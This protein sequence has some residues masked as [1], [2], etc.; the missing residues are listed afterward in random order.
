MNENNCRLFSKE[1]DDMQSTTTSNLSNQPWCLMH[2][3]VVL[4]DLGLFVIL[5]YGVWS[6]ETK[7]KDLY[8]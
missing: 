7:D 8:L 5:E 3:E 4:L 1:F 2:V 6:I